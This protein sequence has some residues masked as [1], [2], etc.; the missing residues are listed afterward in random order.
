MSCLTMVDDEDSINELSWLNW[1]CAW[2]KGWRRDNIRWPFVVYWDIG[3]RR[4]WDL[5]SVLR[6]KISVGGGMAGVLCIHL[7]FYS[8]SGDSGISGCLRMLHTI[9]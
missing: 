2:V 7:S 3:Y 9:D 8:M 5:S 4:D 1:R 6:S